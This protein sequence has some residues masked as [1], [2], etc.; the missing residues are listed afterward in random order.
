M[1]KFMMIWIGELISSIGSGMTAFA[2][3]I[4]VYQLTGSVS[5]VSLITLLAYMPT[6]LLSPLGGVLADRYDRRLLMIIGDLFSGLGLLYILWQIQ[7]GNT[8]IQP[9][10][11]GV[12]FNAVF[13]ALLEPSYRATVTDLLTEDEYDKASGMVQIAGNAKY[14]ISPALA[15]IILGV[16]DIRVIL[17]ID[18]CTFI[19]TVSMVAMVRKTVKKPV[20]K[21][22]QGVFHEMKEGLGFLIQDR[23]I[24]SL[25][26][27]MAG[28]CFFMGF[29]QTLTS[30]MVLAVSD[31][32]TVGIMESLCAIGMLAGSI[33]IGTAGIKKSYARVLGIAGCFCGIFMAVAGISTNLLVTGAGIFLFFAM[34]P[35]MNTCADVLVRVSIPNALQGRV[36]GMISLLTQVGT[37]VAYMICGVLADYVFEPMFCEGGLLAD[38]VGNLIGTG[39]GRGIGFML[40]LSGVGMLVAS[41][42]IGRNKSIQEIQVNREVSHV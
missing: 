17:L 8:G 6:I 19:I 18:I 33:W 15:G 39:Q 27:L 7:M 12:T 34:L 22:H 9:I 5:Y 38:S 35:F 31:A 30:P 21:E 24:R 32:R 4:Y 41:L 2:L 36:W 40:I 1:K 29:V 28:V 14:L 37:V 23:G 11:I 26:L 10:L 13:V 42:A 16:A 20:T 3:S 25:V